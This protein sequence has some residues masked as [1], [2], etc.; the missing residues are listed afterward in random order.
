[1]KKG[2]LLA[3]VAVLAMAGTG[4]AATK[5]IWVD[6]AGNSGDSYRYYEYK[7]GNRTL[8]PCC[9]GW[10]TAGSGSYV[11]MKWETGV[12]LSKNWSF[13][14]DCKTADPYQVKTWAHVRQRGFS[15]KCD[16]NMKSSISC[17]VTCNWANN[18]SWHLNMQAYGG[19]DPSGKWDYADYWTFDLM[20][21][22]NYS[23]SRS[24]WKKVTVDG[25]EWYKQQRWEGKDKNGKTLNRTTIVYAKKNK[26]YKHKIN[27]KPFMEDSYLNNWYLGSLEFGWEVYTG[28]AK[29]TVNSMG[30]N[31]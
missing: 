30:L 22:P 23:G 14:T 26:T 21:R 27:I 25:Q 9:W 1:M 16:S 12:N 15:K 6:K 29:W 13:Q 24:H 2:T 5:E 3:T 4:F 18:P 10:A 17:D 20:I 31:P 7:E 28:T 8:T 11:L 19:Q